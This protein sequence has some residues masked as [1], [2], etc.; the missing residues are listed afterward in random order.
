MTESQTPPDQI[1]EWAIALA[2]QLVAMTLEPDAAVLAR[3]LDVAI[4]SPAIAYQVICCL[5][6]SIGL[7]LRPN[8]HAG[9]PVGDVDGAPTHWHQAAQLVGF[10]AQGD[11]EMVRALALAAVLSPT[12][13]LLDAYWLLRDMLDL[14]ASEPIDPRL[15]NTP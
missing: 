10:A 6:R 14:L 9:G 5:A 1:D 13:E 11:A 4:E 2:Q 3:Q 15:E 8:G 7:I 12:P